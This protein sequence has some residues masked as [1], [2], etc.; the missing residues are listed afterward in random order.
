M[1]LRKE[2]AIWFSVTIVLSLIVG[3][4]VPIVPERLPNEIWSTDAHR[5]ID[6]QL[7]LGA[8]RINDLV[9]VDGQFP[10][11]AYNLAVIVGD[12]TYRH[13]IFGSSRAGTSVTSTIVYGTFLP[14]GIPFLDYDS[15]EEI[16]KITPANFDDFMHWLTTEEAEKLLSKS[17][18]DADVAPSP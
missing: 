11:P 9:L 7:E 15:K 16:A 12:T 2:K 4:I 8:N 14:E 3:F 10:K 18:P 6:S 1:K 5:K 13:S 17:K